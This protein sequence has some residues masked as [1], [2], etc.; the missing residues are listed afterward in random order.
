MDKNNSNNKIIISLLAVLIIAVLGVGGYFVIKD[1]TKSQ[2]PESSQ[3]NSNNDSNHNSTSNQNNTSGSSN[4]DTSASESSSQSPQPEQAAIE[5]S[6][7]Y[8]EIRGDDYYIEAQV[9]GA[10]GGTCDISLVPTNGGQGHHET[11][12]LDIEGG[13]SICDEDF[14]LRG[15]GRGEHKITVII[16][17]ADGREKTLEKIV[18]I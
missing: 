10:V 15:L 1:A 9:K 8:S 13:I 4:S 12:K 6:I 7:A 11:D 14:S 5:A 3:N 17:A 2:N 16:R 18:N